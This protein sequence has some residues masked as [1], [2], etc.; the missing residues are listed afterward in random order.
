MTA[1][2]ALPAP[3]VA[4]LLSLAPA[5]QDPPGGFLETFALAADRGAA[6]ETLLPGSEDEAYYRCLHAQNTGDLAAA[7][8]ILA[9][10][11]KQR[12]ARS[13]ERWAK[14][15]KRQTL[16]A[17]DPASDASWKGLID[18]LDLSFDHRASAPGA[19][20]NLPS[21]LDLAQLTDRAWIERSLA[22]R[23]GLKGMRGEALASLV[24]TNPSGS[25][26]RQLLDA[27]PRPDVEGL[28]PLVLAELADRNSDG[29]G[30]RGVHRLLLLDQLQALA[31]ARPGLL[32]ESDFVDAMLSRMRPGEDSDLDRDPVAMDAYLARLEAFVAT[33]PPGHNDLRAHVLYHRLRFDL[34]RETQPELDAQALLRYLAIPRS[35]GYASL[36]PVRGTEAGNLSKRPPTGLNAVRSDRAMIEAYFDRLFP[37]LDNWDAYAEFL[38][39]KELD[40]RVAEAKLLAGAPDPE[41]WYRLLGGAKPFAKLESQV[42]LDFVPHNPASFGGTEPVALE[43]D[44]KNVQQLIVQVYALEPLNWYLAENKEISERVDLSGL[45]P[46]SRTA[47]R[48]DEPKIRRVRRRFELDSIQEPGVYVVEFVGGGLS[49]RAIVRK[50]SLDFVEHEDAA[51]HLFH[52]VDE[53]GTLLPDAS[54]WSQGQEY[55]ADDTG[56]I[57]LPFTAEPKTAK[58][59]LAHGNQAVRT[60]FHHHA[61]SYRLELGALAPREALLPGT[62][63]A[64]VLRPRLFAGKQVTQ[65]AWIEDP[66]LHVEIQDQSGRKSTRVLP[67]DS[68]PADAELTVPIEDLGGLPDDWIDLRVQLKGQIQYV[69]IGERRALESPPVHLS[70]PAI[71]RSHQV[72][73]P[74]LRRLASGYALEFRG[75]SG[76]LLAGQA[77]TVGLHHPDHDLAHTQTLVSDADGRIQLGDL[78]GI[79][80][81]TADGFAGKRRSWDFDLAGAAPADRL[82]DL[83]MN[84]SGTLSLPHAGSIATSALSL[85]ELREGNFVRDASNAIQVVPGAVRIQGLEPGDYSLLWRATGLEQRLRVTAG[86]AAEARTVGRWTLGR[87]RALELP[88]RPM[89]GIAE[90]SASQ[91]EVVLTLSGARPDTRVHVFAQRFAPADDLRRRLDAGSLAAPRQRSREQAA[92]RYQGSRKLSGEQRYVLERRFRSAFPGNMLSARPGLLLNEW[93]T[94]D[95]N[96]TL[97]I[98]GGAGGSTGSRFGGGSGKDSALKAGAR[99]AAMSPA[100]GFA[101]LGFLPAAT[102]VLT[103]LRPDANGVLRIPRGDLGAGQHLVVLAADALRVVRRDLV[104]DEQPLVP[105]DRRLAASLDPAKQYAMRRRFLSLQEG[106]T[107]SVGR[108]AGAHAQWVG[109][110]AGAHEL[111]RTLS[112]NSE[113][114]RFAF[115][116]SWPSLTEERKAELY[117][118]FAC[119]E[120]HVFL[121]QKDSGFFEAVVRPY[122]ANKGERTFLDHWLLD[123]DLTPYLEPYPYSR[124]NALERIL[125]GARLPQ[126]ADAV[127]R[128]AR[129]GVAI[130]GWTPSAQAEL[131]E[132]ALAQAPSG[133]PGV[134]Q[135]V[136][137]AVAKPS[138]GGPATPGPASPG[139]P[140]DS[141][142]PA[143]GGVLADIEEIEEETGSDDFFL[144]RGETELAR[145]R[146]RA[147]PRWNTPGLTKAHVE[148]HYWQV[149]VAQMVPGLVPLNP[150]W[151]DLAEHLATD[152]AARSPFVSPHL[153]RSTGSLAEMLLALAFLDLPFAAPEHDVQLSADAWSMTAAGPALVLAKELIPAD[154]STSPVPLAVT[155]D[156]VRLDDRL[157][158]VEGRTRVKLVQGELQ[159]GVPYAALV[160]VTNPTAGDL[161]AQVLVQVPAG[162]VPLR[163]TNPTRA[164]EKKLQARSSFAAEVPFYFPE[165]GT[166]P[167]APAQVSLGGAPQAAAQPRSLDVRAEGPAPDPSAWSTIAASGTTE[168]VLAALGAANLGETDL[169]LL[170]WRL[171]DPGFYAALHADLAARLHYHPLVWSYGFLHRDTE[172]ASDYL[173]QQSRVVESLGGYLR[174]PLLHLDPFE[175]GAFMEVELSPLIQ[176]RMHPFGRERHIDNDALRAQWSRLM[177]WLARKPNLESEDQLTLSIYLLAQG[178]IEE[179]IE[180]HAAVD[181]AR[182][183]T[184]IQYDY[185][186][187]YLAFFGDDPEAARSIAAAYI[188]HPVDRWRMR[189]SEV[190]AHLDEAAGGAPLVTD[191]SSQAQRQGALAAADAQLSLDVVDGMLNLS[192]RGA[193]EIELRYYEMD[194]EQLFSASPFL[195]GE[196]SAS[197]Y[198]QPREVEVLRPAASTYATERPIPTAF[199]DRNTLVE[200]RGGGQVARKLALSCWFDVR[201]SQ[202][203]GQLQVTHRLDGQPVRG[204]YVKVFRRNKDG[205][206]S[207]H[208]D[209]ATDL[210]GRFDYASLTGK[211]KASNSRFAI[212]VLTDDGAAHVQEV[213]APAR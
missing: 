146:K 35:R 152:P 105:V 29:F 165:A 100:S 190:I 45:V 168:E 134:L 92:T 50:G 55:R 34:E 211:V 41:R 107:I 173:R 167:M 184:R 67:L 85:L 89:L 111:L 60:S 198:V 120:L 189:F 213:D 151:L 180:R 8:A 202:A 57:R 207:F 15:R 141:P 191:P 183:R 10:Q 170:A 68:L 143:A 58:V 93:E 126:A 14:L 65:L 169:S 96:E 106:G 86:P 59:I 153:A 163:G 158:T 61:E 177:G 138:P 181:P 124:L 72:G 12:N 121:R 150:Y 9:S 164:L 25:R 76:E 113:L 79:E 81:L 118:E 5:P 178:R 132:R 182:I 139:A 115:L 128:W 114:D 125:L 187:A 63:A 97:G 62:Q 122:L 108:S 127:R 78:D 130:D 19:Q 95:T 194:I 160:T 82:R 156:L 91:D 171:A 144:G 137:K 176:A 186:S 49:S 46:G 131:F 200:A 39:A 66:A 84:A 90:L 101:D 94:R 21:T 192:S 212:L 4:A 80:R 37:A 204:A 43:L 135:E 197:A 172:A 11:K 99:L 110:L 104:L 69:S 188:E 148:R 87:T 161:D 209:G 38:R 27:L 74:L 51:G 20:R 40:A 102:R 56:A 18:L 166:F 206:V 142:G 155:L 70:G 47:L 129:D 52:V 33:L 179:A 24:L 162:A 123:E 6:L 75:R 1:L 175:S 54:I 109:D 205:K 199:A 185:L 159:Q 174:S 203:Y 13:E 42:E 71:Q 195:E 193:A 133:G 44:V 32:E 147:K 64:L 149:P 140:A 154:P 88:V 83:H 157:E 36:D 17:F 53:A 7:D 2:P 26:R 116:T 23:A 16:L 98:G 210:R 3:F 119:H 201:L 208:K 28:V 136:S 22:S 48:F 112:G 73:A 103:N 31:A 30:S 145:D 117:S 196:R 77:V